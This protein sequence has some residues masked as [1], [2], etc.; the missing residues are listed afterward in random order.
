MVRNVSCNDVGIIFVAAAGNG[1]SD[2]IG[3]DNDA[4]PVYPASFELPNV[5]SVAATT[6]NDTMC[7]FSNYGVT[8][9]DL[10]A[11]GI[12]IYST[13]LNSKYGTKN[14]TSMACPHVTGAIALVAAEF[15]NEGITARIKRIIDNVDHIPSLSGKCVTGGRLNVFKAISSNFTI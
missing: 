14:G 5:V 2:Q 12:G 8:S 9:V 10:G 1:G 7:K 3:D 4:K 6:D 13:K 15:P 11:P